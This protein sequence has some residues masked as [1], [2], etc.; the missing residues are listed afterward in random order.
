MHPIADDQSKGKYVQIRQPYV[1]LCDDNSPPI[2]QMKKS[3]FYLLII[4]GLRDCSY[5]LSI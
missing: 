2:H 3:D 4:L 1:V 5:Y